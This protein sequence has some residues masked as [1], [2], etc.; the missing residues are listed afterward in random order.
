MTQFARP[1]PA[2]PDSDSTIIGALEGSVAKLCCGSPL[3]QS[4]GMNDPSL[5]GTAGLEWIKAS[6]S[7]PGS[8]QPR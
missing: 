3:A 1:T 2:A 5:G 6:G 8:S 4:S 7:R